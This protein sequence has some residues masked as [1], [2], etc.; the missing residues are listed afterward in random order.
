M[1]IFAD[2]L[3]DIFADAELA[4]D[5]LYMPASGDDSTVRVMRRRPTDEAA[6]L[7][8][9]YRGPQIEMDVLAAEV[10]APA[11]GDR[12]AIGES[13]WTVVGVRTDALGVLHTL[14]VRPA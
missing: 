12:L 13:T 7:S 11:K 4:E 1:S 8:A 3:A 5:A 2:A 14:E 6:L 10:A 9:G